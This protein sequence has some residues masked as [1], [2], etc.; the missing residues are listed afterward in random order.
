M[1][2]FLWRY[3]FKSSTH[4]T[5]WTGHIFAEY[6]LYDSDMAQIIAHHIHSSFILSLKKTVSDNDFRLF[7]Q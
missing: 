2:G 3:A 4:S 5:V 7:A 6:F 1:F